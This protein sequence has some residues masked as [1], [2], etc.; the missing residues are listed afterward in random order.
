MVAKKSRKN[1]Q[2]DLRKL[3]KQE[4]GP[5]VVVMA[6]GDPQSLTGRRGPNDHQAAQD[7][8]L[9]RSAL[10][11]APRVELISPA[12]AYL[13][14]HNDLAT[15]GPQGLVQLMELYSNPRYS[16]GGDIDA[17]QAAEVA[18]IMRE[19]LQFEDLYPEQSVWNR[20][21]VKNNPVYIYKK[22]LHDQVLGSGHDSLRSKMEH[23]Y[24]E[25][26]QRY[27][28][29]Q[30]QAAI[31][32]GALVF[33]GSDFFSD[34]NDTELDLSKI[35]SQLT[36]LLTDPNAHVLMDDHI[37]E[38]AGI[39]SVIDHPFSNQALKNSSRAAT[40]SRF[41]SHLPVFPNAAMEDILTARKDL[42]TLRQKYFRAV[43][44]FASNLD[45]SVLEKDHAAEIDAMWRDEVHPQVVELTRATAE[46]R[47]GGL[48]KFTTDLAKRFPEKP[49]LTATFGV[50]SFGLTGV[51]LDTIIFNALAGFLGNVGM[52]ARNIA[53]ER[54]LQREKQNKSGLQ[55]LVELTKVL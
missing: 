50:A 12:V 19:M 35:S 22:A 51:D 23:Q 24:R 11:H 16:S 3:A 9:V 34:N 36:K 48:A 39:Q 8:R 28:G 20:P 52:N 30:V 37:R 42:A 47:L 15:S 18:Q 38:L 45:S 6:I 41:I 32:S 2:R 13:K 49:G 31:D 43:G 55:Y 44:E 21:D 5:T 27:G 25:M 26:W 46:T 40:G 17:A 10:L 54:R 29:D 7:V 53:K 33:R 14:R 1:Q 4:Y